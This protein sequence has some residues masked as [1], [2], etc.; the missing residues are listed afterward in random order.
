MTIVF[1]LLKADNS[2]QPGQ[3][4]SQTKGVSFMDRREFGSTGRNVSVIGQ[5]SYRLDTIPSSD[6]MNVIRKGID[7][8]ANHIDTAE[9]YGDGKVEQVLGHALEGYR[10]RVFLVSKVSP[11]HASRKGTVAAC[12]ASLR[13]LHTDRLDC[14]LLHWPSDHPIEETL[15]AFQDLESAG[16]IGAWGVSNFARHDL[17]VV[18]ARAGTQRPA[19]NQ[20]FYHMDERGAEHEVI[21]FCREEGIA[22]VA[23]SPFGSGSFPSPDTPRGRTLRDVAARHG[24]TPHQLALSFLTRL[25]HMFAIPRST[26]AAHVLEN[27]AAGKIQLGEEELRILDEAFAPGPA[28]AGVPTI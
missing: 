12:E 3:K 7:A 15:A 10:D 25:P 28:H 11:E 14:Y 13:R 5:G 4:L 8:G 1:I 19:C 27:A 16:K 20:I 2:N 24:V 18:M 6:A 26:D 17:E 22:V 21:P 9:S 23:Y